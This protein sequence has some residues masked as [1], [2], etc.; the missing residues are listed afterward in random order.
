MRAPGAT[1]SSFWLRHDRAGHAGAVRMRVVV[2]AGGVV[3]VGDGAGEIGMRAVDLGIDH[4]DRDVVARGDAVRV[5]EPQLLGHVL[6]GIA[7]LR[8]S[9]T[10]PPASV[11]RVDVVGLRGGDDLVRG[12]RLDH[13]G[14]R[15]GCWRGASG[16]RRCR[17]PAGTARPSTVRLCC[18]R[19]ASSIRLRHVAGHL[20]H[21]L[22]GDEA[23]LV[24][25]RQIEEPV[26]ADI[27]PD[28]L[29][30][31]P[32]AAG[33]CR[34]R[35]RLLRAAAAVVPAAVFAA[36]RTACVRHRVARRRRRD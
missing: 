21:D 28:R 19:M 29:R 9:P 1:P 5:G 30:A 20:Q 3:A 33:R 22:V 12:E 8:R 15:S 24:G 6:A 10:A 4:R 18:L 27:E 23:G 17:R 35:C 25:R 11:Q 32:D 34:G 13:G 2:D 36:A 7:L 26:L 31:E 16:R 14:D